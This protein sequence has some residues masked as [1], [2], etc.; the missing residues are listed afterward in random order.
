[1]TEREEGTRDRR[2]KCDETKQLG[3]TNAFR[4]GNASSLI[5]RADN[6]FHVSKSNL[7]LALYSYEATMVED[8]QDKGNPLES[9]IEI[10]ITSELFS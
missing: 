2:A 9:G 3:P 6:S 1:M 5:L 7:K 10:S 8:F 4:Q